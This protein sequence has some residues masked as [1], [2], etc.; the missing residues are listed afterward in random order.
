MRPLAREFG[1]AILAWLL[2]F[3]AAIAMSPWRESRRPLFES[4]I[5]VALAG[6]TVFLASIYFRRPRVRY[7]AAGVRIGILWMLANWALDALMFSSGPMQ[8]SLEQYVADIGVT[9]LMIPVITIG[10]GLA[11]AMG[12]ARG[13]SEA[14]P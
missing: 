7:L 8:M 5:A 6:S 14:E 4:L 2:P 1:F 13:A 10:L 12:R 3:I 11:A 9:Y